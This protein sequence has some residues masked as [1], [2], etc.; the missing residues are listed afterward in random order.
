[1]SSIVFFAVNML[2]LVLIYV[3]C[4]PSGFFI[5]RAM[6]Q[7]ARFA[8]TGWSEGIL[9]LYLLAFIWGCMLLLYQYRRK[10]HPG[11]SYFIAPALLMLLLNPPVIGLYIS[12]GRS[13]NIVPREL[14]AMA[15]WLLLGFVLV[16]LILFGHVLAARSLYVR[17]GLATIAVVV[18]IYLAMFPGFQNPSPVPL[19]RQTAADS[20]TISWTSRNPAFG[21]VLFGTDEDVNQ[22]ICTA[23]DGL[24]EANNRYH[25]V[26]L[27]NL[28]PG[29]EYFYQACTDDIR[30]FFPNNVD[31]GDTRCSRLR[32]FRLSLPSAEK[33]HSMF[34]AMCTKNPACWKTPL[35]NRDMIFC[36]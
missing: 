7:T 10:T 23:R 5:D 22:R 19:L 27:N 16:G 17:T 32:S 13:R 35:L 8:P 24:L 20:A 18:I 12:L 21:Y 36:C 31:Y 15:P 29:R 25:A 3:A 14:L 2:L 9:V 34:S 30:D 1:M 28:E 4:R 11:R 26:T 33:P 6:Y